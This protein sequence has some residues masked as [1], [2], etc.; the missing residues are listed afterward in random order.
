MT[1]GRGTGEEAMDTPD[2]NEWIRAVKAQPDAGGIGMILT[3]LGV[4]RGTSRSG[5]PVTGMDLTVDQARLA[6]VLAETATW[7]GVVA[8]RAWVSEGSLAVGD[9][10]MKVLVAGDIREHVFDALQRLVA[11]IKTEVVSEVERH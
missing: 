3:H 10:I 8:V 9:D 7:P 2:I 6:E 5:T 4:V 11:L 1:C